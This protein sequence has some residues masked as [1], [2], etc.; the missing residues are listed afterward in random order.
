MRK[1]KRLSDHD[2][3]EMAMFIQFL[4][5]KAVM[6]PAD[7]YHKY[8]DYCGLTDEELAQIAKPTKGKP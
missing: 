8:Q 2:A 4:R 7:L 6:K 1:V 3:K 5:A